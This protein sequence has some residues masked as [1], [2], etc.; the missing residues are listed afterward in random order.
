MDNICLSCSC[1]P[2]PHPDRGQAMNYKMEVNNAA[3]FREKCVCV[4][5]WINGGIMWSICRIELSALFCVVRLKY[6]VSFGYC[7]S[8]K[9]KAQLIRLARVMVMAGDLEKWYV[10]KE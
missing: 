2:I 6:C 9:M 10:Q 1:H 3:F 5:A 8:R 7:T 4:L